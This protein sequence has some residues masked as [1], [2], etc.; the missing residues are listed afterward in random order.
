MNELNSEQ[1]GTPRSRKLP[2]TRDQSTVAK[3]NVPPKPKHNK[4]LSAYTKKNVTNLPNT[5]VFANNKVKLPAI[6]VTDNDQRRTATTIDSKKE[7]A[8]M[9][10]E[11]K[12]IIPPQNMLR[13]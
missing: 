8:E 11:E 13:L 5:K 9:E 4:G 6:K 1:P 2:Q 3:G 10:K 7:G 12:D